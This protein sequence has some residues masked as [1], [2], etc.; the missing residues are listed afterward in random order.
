MRNYRPINLTSQTCRV[1]EAI[2]K[3]EILASLQESQVIRSS[4]HGFLPNISC[5]TNLL[6]YLEYVTRNVD[7]GVP[8]DTIYLDFSK[9]FD[10]VPHERLLM[11]MRSVGIDSNTVDWDKDWLSSRK[12][13]VVLKGISSIRR[14]CF[15]ERHRPNRTRV[16]LQMGFNASK[17]KTRHY[18]HGNSKRIYKI[19]G[20]K[21]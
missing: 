19:N 8:V 1:M 13:R 15:P 7:E 3:E 6:T 14:R 21:N 17:C 5:Q 16:L 9:A 20:K 2:L 4:Q 18:G 11:K 10:S 12:Q